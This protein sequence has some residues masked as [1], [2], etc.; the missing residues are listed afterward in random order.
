MILNNPWH[1]LNIDISNAIRKDFDYNKLREES[2]FKDAPAALYRFIDY[3]ENTHEFFNKEWLEYMRAQ[4]IPVIG[5]VL[6]YRRAGYLDYPHIDLS[7]NKTPGEFALNWVITDNDDS[8]MTWY[9]AENL[10][11]YGKDIQYNNDPSGNWANLTRFTIDN[12]KQYETHECTLGKTLTLVDVATPHN[13][14]MG[15]NDRWCISVRCNL[16][17]VSNW[18]DTVN[19]FE[20]FIL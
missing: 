9:N 7:Y 2:F 3:S 5:G 20:K 16:R 6:F 14:V 10:A 1:K 17:V 12:Y 13:I 19:Y 8:K 15:L 18:Q 4:G 11:P